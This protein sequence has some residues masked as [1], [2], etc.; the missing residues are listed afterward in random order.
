MKMKKIRTFPDPVLKARADEVTDINGE[1]QQLI[2]DMGA[3]MYA[4]PGLGLAA[5]QVG[6][7]RRVIVFD[8]SQKEGHQRSPGGLNP[9]ITAGEGEIDPRGRLSVGRSTFPPRCGVMPRCCV[10]GVDRDGKPVTV[11][12][13]GLLAVVLQHEIDHLERD[14][15]HRPHQPPETGALSPAAEKTGGDR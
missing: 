13:E 15:V 7:L 5:N 1:L 9:C 12:G 11:D 3:T 6:D 10:S 8:V 14:S 4:A 2:D